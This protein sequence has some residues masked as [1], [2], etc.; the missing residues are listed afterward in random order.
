MAECLDAD[1]LVAP[2]KEDCE[3]SISR[4]ELEKKLK[5]RPDFILEEHYC[6]GMNTFCEDAGLCVELVA[7]A[8]LPTRFGHFTLYGFY[9]AKNDKEHTAVVK[10]DVK[11]KERVPLR[12]HSQCHTGDVLGSLRCDCRDQLEA[13]LSYINGQEFGAVVYMKQEGRGIGLL[14][15]IKAYQLQDLGLDTVEA[16][17]YLGYPDEGREYSVA[18]RII[19][20]L[21][22][23]SVALLTNNPDKIEKLRNEGVTVVDRIPIV[24]PPNPFDETYLKTKRERMNHLI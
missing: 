11:G 24:I 13:A 23:Q 12:V 16:N 21:G 9:D 1:P 18:A 3:K 22:I 4:E 20:L 5:G 7:H 8:D 6:R 15:K 17:Q 19:E 14:N 2:L 10:G